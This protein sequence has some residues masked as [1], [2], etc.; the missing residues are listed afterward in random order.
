MIAITT[1]QNERINGMLQSVTEAGKLRIYNA[2]SFTDF[3]F[4]EIQYHKLN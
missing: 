3:S 2:N 4:G 1:N